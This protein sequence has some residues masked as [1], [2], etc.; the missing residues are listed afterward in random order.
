MNPIRLSLRECQDD[1]KIM[2]FLENARLG[3]LGLSDK[4]AP[5][6]VPLNFVWFNEVIYFHGADS[7]RKT[8][9]LNENSN[10]CFTVCEE[11]GTI[12]HPVPAHTDTAY[13]SVMV[14]G[15]AEPVTDLD[16]ATRVMQHML[17]KYVPGYYDRK[18]SKNHVEKY[19]SSLGSKTAI[20]RIIPDSITAKENPMNE[21]RAY[22]PGRKVTGD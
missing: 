5:Y 21:E 6:V 2:S 19:R 22:Y 16:E 17:D 20:Y 1:T 9:I 10:T 4:L 3:F 13:M 12:T 15:Q 7:G 8:S 11:Y 18:L 14:F